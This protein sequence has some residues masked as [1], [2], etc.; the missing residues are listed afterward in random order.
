MSLVHK[1]YICD[2][3]PDLP[4]TTVDI[5]TDDDGIA[6]GWCMLRSTTRGEVDDAGTVID[7]TGNRAI[8]PLHVCPEC[9]ARLRLAGVN[10]L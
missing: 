7:A 4:P 6:P 5:A 8:G 1:R 2:V 9:R 3:C 10:Q